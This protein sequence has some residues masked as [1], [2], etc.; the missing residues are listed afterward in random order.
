MVTIPDEAPGRGTKAAKT[1][2]RNSTDLLMFHEQI[3]KVP[4]CEYNNLFL[5]TALTDG[6]D[7]LVMQYIPEYRAGGLFC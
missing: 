5:Q 4:E 6:T 2:L 7:V 1:N 3:P